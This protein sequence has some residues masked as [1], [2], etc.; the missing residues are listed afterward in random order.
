MDENL[1]ISKEK[2][3]ELQPQIEVWK[4]KHGKVGVLQVELDDG[5]SF[6]GIFR[7][8]TQQDTKLAMR[9]ELDASE[10]NRELCRLTVLY[11]EPLE[12]NTIF[13]AEWGIAVPLAK[14][15]LDW[16]NVT[17]EATIKKL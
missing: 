14:K 1:T 8:P 5:R 11:P 16:S 15:L 3:E 17:K 10:S 13:A 9:K 12:L 7:V 6:E 2:L 4:E